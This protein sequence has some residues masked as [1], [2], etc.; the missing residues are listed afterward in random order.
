M[1][2]KTRGE[3]TLVGPFQIGKTEGPCKSLPFDA[4]P[5]MDAALADFLTAFVEQAATP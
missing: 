1:V 3:I 4:Q 2:A 5:E